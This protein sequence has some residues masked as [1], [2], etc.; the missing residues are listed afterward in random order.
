MKKL[1]YILSA[2][3]VLSACSGKDEAEKAPDLNTDKKRISYAMGADHA[4]QLV[5]SRDKNFDKY[6]K[7]KI[8]EGFGLGLKDPN[9]F[10]EECQKTIEKLIGKSGQE[11]N[12]QY[13]DESSLCIGKVMGSVF[14]TGWT[15][16][17]S[18]DK[19]DMDMVKYGFRAALYK[20]D[21]LIDQAQRTQMVQTFIREITDKEM[22]KVV[23]MEKPFFEEVK[24]K[25]GI[26]ALPEGLYLE[27]VRAGK[28]GKPSPGDDVKV[29]YALTNIMGDTI[30]SS[31]EAAAK[32]QEMPAFSLNRV[33]RGWSVGLTHMNKGGAYRLYV[34]TQ[35][36]YGKE[37][38]V[39]YIELE[40]YGKPG[41]LAKGM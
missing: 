18:L 33:I 27:T 5:N 19:F 8:V 26:Q 2:A 22:A 35:M 14:N 15:E 4:S 1:L 40:D 36:A 31:F 17:K 39:F 11:F 32:G 20:T 24:K 21:T 9:A 37:P 23:Q 29:N 12:M 13:V 38:L 28:G 3:F 16:K 6:N 25:P 30:E 34:P 7:E 41:T 10:G